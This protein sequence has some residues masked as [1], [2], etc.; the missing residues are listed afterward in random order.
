[1]FN[2]TLTFLMLAIVTAILGFTEL[3]GA[4][5]GLAQILFVA[6]V[7]LLAASALSRVAHGRTH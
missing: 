2:W 7:I 5:A 3:A 6:F 4:L 1:M